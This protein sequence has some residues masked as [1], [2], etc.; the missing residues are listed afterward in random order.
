VRDLARSI[1]PVYPPCLNP[2]PGLI[3]TAVVLL[4]HDRAGEEHLLFEVR[5]QHVEHHKGE[6]S[7]PGGARDQENASLR[8]AALRELHEEIGVHPDSLEIFGRLD[9][10]TT[11]TNFVM[12][13]YVGAITRPRPYPFRTATIEVDKLLEVPLAH[14]LSPV[15]AEETLDAAGRLGRSFRFG[16][17]LIFGATARVLDSFLGRLASAGEGRAG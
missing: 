8:D 3:P 4:L 2:A 5:S 1:F 14:L 11:R 12:A 6:I 10:F 9:D 15:S 16:D 7:L 13:P 17:Q